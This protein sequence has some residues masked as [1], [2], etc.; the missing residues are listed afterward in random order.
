MIALYI[1]VSFL[2]T[3]LS[4][5]IFRVDRLAGIC[6]FL[7]GF[8]FIMYFHLPVL[9]FL[10]IIQFIPQIRL[11]WKERLNLDKLPLDTPAFVLDTFVYVL[12]GVS[13]RKYMA[14]TYSNFE[15]PW[16]ADIGDWPPL[17]LWIPCI[18]GGYVL[19]GVGQGFVV[20]LYLYLRSRYSRQLKPVAR[21]ADAEEHASEHAGET[22]PLL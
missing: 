15:D 18:W 9:P 7:A 5:L 4:L 20:V 10:T 2:P 12:V 3:M 22:T 13:W 21:K 17:V 11:I 6:A 19:F 1:V 16:D 14:S 8:M